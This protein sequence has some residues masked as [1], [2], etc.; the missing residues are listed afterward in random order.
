MYAEGDGHWLSQPVAKAL[1]A[2][3]RPADERPIPWIV[4]HALSLM[5]RLGEGMRKLMGNCPEALRNRL[6]YLPDRDVSD[7]LCA[8]PLTPGREKGYLDRFCDWVNLPCDRY[9]R[10]WYIRTHECRKS[11]LITFF[12]SYR[13]ASLDA[14]RWI[15]GHRDSRDVYAY[16]QAN[17][18]GMELPTIESQY[19]SQQLWLHESGGEAEVDNIE[20]LYRAVCGHFRVRSISL[21]EESEINSW[22]E[23]AF[24]RGRYA[25][26]P[27]SVRVDGQ[28][29]ETRICFR[30]DTRSDDA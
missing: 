1:L 29:A 27:Y 15:A 14:A 4:G 2:G 30:V 5:D 17:F 16:I 12:W 26:E 20:D 28:I 13:Y 23:L 25:I 19:A 6:F 11:F 9:G 7:A 3:E 8:G 18:P 24:A 21:L 22:L 10:R